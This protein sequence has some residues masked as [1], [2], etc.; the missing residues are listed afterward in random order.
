MATRASA[1]PVRHARH[2]L[3]RP[4][5]ATRAVAA[6]RPGWRA[7]TVASSRGEPSSSSPSPSRRAA[8]VSALAGAAFGARDLASAR[9]ALAGERPVDMKALVRAFDEA[10]SAG[11]DFAKADEAWTRAIAIAPTNA[12]AWS[13]RGTKRLQAGRWADARDD[14]ER[15][16]ELSPDPDA[17]D[18][19]TLN[20]LGNAEGALGRWDAA[21]ANYLEASKNREME[22]I[23]LANF[24]LAKFQVGEVEDAL[25]TTRRILRRDPEFWDMRAAQAAFLW[26]A[27]D[28]AQAESEWSALCRSGRGF[29]AAASAEAMRG[30]DGG[31]TPAYAVELLEQQIRQQAAVVAGVVAMDGARKDG[32]ES[33]SRSGSRDD[34]HADDTPCAVY[35]DVKIVAPRWPPR[36]TAALDAFLGVRRTGKAMDYDGEVKEYAFGG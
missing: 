7:T 22:S 4:R 10:M 3:A 14:L 25:K 31:V 32:R 15:S 18:P 17:P 36:C 6:A 21:M 12:A 33:G 9:V 30:E 5:R 24:A 20:N 19:L 34:L 13:N 27:G 2:A 1:S 23:A 35:A 29:G 28:E 16:V 26:A 8:L 11:S